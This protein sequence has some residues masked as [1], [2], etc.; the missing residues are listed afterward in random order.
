MTKPKVVKAWAVSRWTPAQVTEALTSLNVSH[1][2]VGWSKDD[3]KLKGYHEDGLSIEQPAWPV[4]THSIADLPKL[5]LD[6]ERQILFV[7][8]SVPA[9]ANLNL[10][11][12]P[13]GRD[14]K[15]VLKRALQIMDDDWVYKS[16]EPDIQDFVAM[17]SKPSLLNQI[18]T[19]VYKINP[20]SE[21][22]IIQNKIVMFLG[23]KV[24]ISSMRDTLR[25]NFKYEPI[26]ELLNKPEAVTLRNAVEEARRT[27]EEIDD[28]AE[29]L[30]IEAFDISYI[31]S[32]IMKQN[33]K[34]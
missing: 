32:S 31:L 5:R 34:V 24:S 1:T 25:S 11:P 22:K 19:A 20:Y 14:I 18:L 33:G 2:V 27:G 15:V 26:R 3:H 21:R 6:K 4:V 17:A 23:G 8:D 13:E 16:T 29:R 9:L 10:T 28:L 12:L 7:C 30:G